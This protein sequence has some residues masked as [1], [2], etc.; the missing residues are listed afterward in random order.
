MKLLPVAKGSRAPEFFEEKNDCAVRAIA[1][2]CGVS[3][4]KAHKI[5]AEWGRA[6]RES[7]PVDDFDGALK[8]TGKVK[9][10][11]S[12]KKDCFVIGKLSEKGVT[13]GKFVKE[14]DTGTWVVMLC[15]HLLVVEAGNII[16]SGFT[17]SR[18]PVYYAWKV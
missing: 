5:C 2:A 8:S 1:N 16:D 13:L 15:D 11:T 9:H 12:F 14:N 10:V 3:Y 7:M 6:K 18:S 17:N 4:M